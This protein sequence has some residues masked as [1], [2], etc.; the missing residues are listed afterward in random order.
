M[1]IARVM[2]APWLAVGLLLGNTLFIGLGVV[3]AL[4][5]YAHAKQWPVWKLALLLTSILLI[6]PDTVAFISKLVSK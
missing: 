4:V 1:S 5:A 6:V 2:F 3:V